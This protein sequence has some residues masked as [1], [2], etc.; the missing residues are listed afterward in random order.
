MV[1]SKSVSTMQETKWI[2]EAA[3]EAVGSCLA[4]NVPRFVTVRRS[5][6]RK[7]SISLGKPWKVRRGE[8]KS[9]DRR[10]KGLRRGNEW[11]C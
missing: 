7:F 8:Q 11:S 10:A 4:R 6:V 5:S 2:Y 9:A 1:R 3:I